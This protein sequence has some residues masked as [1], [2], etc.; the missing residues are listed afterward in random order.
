M[1]ANLEEEHPKFGHL[2][3]STSGPL[4]CSLSGAALLQSPILNKGSAFT[5]KERKD[6]NL[7]GLLPPNIQTLDEQVNRAYEQYS[8][9]STALGKNTFMTSL[10]EQNEVLYYK[11]I[12][13]HLKE[14][15][16]IIY[17]PTEGEAIQNYS[18]LF[19]KPDGCFLNILDQDRIHDNLAQLGTAEDFDYIVVTDGEEASF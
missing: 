9:R 10:K 16:S 6:F 19:R 2:P 14:M 5:S 15:F 8:S 12:L 17:T 13:D 3:L 11:L 18:R 7:Y 4:K 1:A